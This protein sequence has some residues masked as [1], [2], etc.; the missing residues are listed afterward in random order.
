MGECAGAVFPYHACANTSPV[1]KS[2]NLHRVSV[3]IFVAHIIKTGSG[4]SFESLK[5]SFVICIKRK[6]FKTKAF[7]LTHRHHYVCIQR[8]RAC[9]VVTR[10]RRVTWHQQITLNNCS[11]ESKA[12]CPIKSTLSHFIL[13]VVLSMSFIVFV[14]CTK[15]SHKCIISS[16]NVC[17]CVCVRERGVVHLLNK[18]S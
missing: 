15:F 7:H 10:T 6:W 3:Q 8:V 13:C 14:W 17:V 4:V 18:H 1:D 2:I 11:P 12:V 9:A 5:S 16:T